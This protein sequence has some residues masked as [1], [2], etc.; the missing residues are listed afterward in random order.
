MQEPVLERRSGRARSTVSA[1]AVPHR[2]PDATVQAQPLG[3]P[4]ASLDIG[5]DTSSAVPALLFRLP[6]TSAG[7]IV[8]RLAGQAPSQDAARAVVFVEA[9]RFM[10]LW[11]QEPGFQYRQFLE[12]PPFT[13][14][15][16][17]KLTE[18]AAQCRDSA[19]MP[20]PLPQVQCLRHMAER[21]QDV[22]RL[23][24]RPQ[25]LQGAQTYWFAVVD[26]GAH[27]L[28]WMLAQG[29]P[30]FPV[31]CDVTQAFRLH[32]AAGLPGTEPSTMPELMQRYRSAG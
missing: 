21:V 16:D 30:V 23:R 24:R 19:R 26:K 28:I 29:V 32:Q 1:P 7:E 13:W 8:L 22:R 27:H 15:A 10:T 31:E 2:L 14:L 20:I 5:T 6:S 12:E 3:G 9:S 17:P 18:A 4:Q 11:Q 25:D